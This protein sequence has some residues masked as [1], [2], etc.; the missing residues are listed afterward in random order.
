MHYIARTLEEWFW[1]P[2]GAWLHICVLFCPSL[3]TE[4]L[5]G[6]ILC[7]QNLTKCLQT[8][9]KNCSNNGRVILSPNRG[10]T[11]YLL[12]VVSF[13]EDWDLARRDPLSTE[14]YEVSTNQDQ[15]FLEHWKSDFE[16]HSGHGCI[17]ASCCVLLWRL[18]PCQAR[19]LVDRFLRSVYKPRPRIADNRGA[20]EFWPVAPQ[21]T[22]DKIIKDYKLWAETSGRAS[23][24]WVAVT[25]ML[26]LRVRILLGAWS[27]CF[28]LTV[29]GFYVGLTPRPEESYRV[30]CVWVL[31]WNLDHKEALTH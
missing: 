15:E 22:K 11:A 5:Q 7:R 26:G 30:W 10:M 8:K 16:P 2:L 29:M 13:F 12:L 14:S 9:T 21:R 25:G 6:A 1:A 3:K 28:V 4:T 23:K 20:A 31:S 18:R 17:C 24:A 27:V 19:S